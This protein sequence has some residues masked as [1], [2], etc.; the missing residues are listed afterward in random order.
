MG[1]SPLLR[2]P[3]SRAWRSIATKKR[4]P[5]PWWA[6]GSGLASSPSFWSGATRL[7]MR[8]QSNSGRA[9][10]WKRGS[11]RSEQIAEA[12]DLIVDGGEPHLDPLALHPGERI[13]PGP[14]HVHGRPEAGIQAIDLLHRGWVQLG[15]LQHGGAEPARP[16]AGLRVIEE[17]E[18]VS[19]SQVLDDAVA[20]CPLVAREQAI[21][22][23]E[24]ILPVVDDVPEDDP[25]AA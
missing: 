15:Q 5:G 7:E 1:R 13:G 6:W 11:G 25:N 24:G 23:L 18:V 19:P 17:G 20:R 4:S 14:H 22:R 21:E 2:W 3:T 9:R 10:T 16:R 12:H 8:S